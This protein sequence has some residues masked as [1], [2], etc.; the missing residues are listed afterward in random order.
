[1]KDGQAQTCYV[2]ISSGTL[3][4]RDSPG[5]NGEIIGRL[6]PDDTVE[7]MDSKN[8]WTLVK[9]EIEAGQGWVKSEY[10]TTGHAATGSYVND[11]GGRLRVR[12]SAGGQEVVRFVKAGKTVA[13][14]S[15]VTDKAGNAWAFVGDGYVRGDCISPAE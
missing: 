14:Q 13:V 15:W 9:A 10:L 12:K 6:Y 7:Y 1:M 4:I 11:S 8:G 3:N 5:F 2:Q